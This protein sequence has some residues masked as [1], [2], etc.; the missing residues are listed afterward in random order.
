MMWQSDGSVNH[1][2]FTLSAL[3]VVTTPDPATVAVTRIE[4]KMVLGVREI[5]EL[6]ERLESSEYSPTSTPNRQCG[7]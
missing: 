3:C 4:I 5:V 2:V 7:T 6:D 1:G